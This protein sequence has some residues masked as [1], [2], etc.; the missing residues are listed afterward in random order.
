MATHKKIRIVWGQYT[1]FLTEKKYKA[2]LAQ[3]RAKGWE[4]F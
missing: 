3:A 2:L 1:Q 4:V